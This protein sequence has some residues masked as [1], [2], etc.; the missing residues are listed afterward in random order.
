MA[1]FDQNRIPVTV[2]L[3]VPEAVNDFCWSRVNGREDYASCVEALG[4]CVRD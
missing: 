4:D 1:A 2:R 3:D